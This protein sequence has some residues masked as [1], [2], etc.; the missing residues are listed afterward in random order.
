MSIWYRNYYGDSYYERMVQNRK[1]YYR[2]EIN[3]ISDDAFEKLVHVFGE[4]FKPILHK[5]ISVENLSELFKNHW[6][7]ENGRRS[8]FSGKIH[9][10]TELDFKE[11]LLDLEKIFKTNLKE[12]YN[13]TENMDYEFS[14]SGYINNINPQVN[15]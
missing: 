5:I 13:L 8:G 12:K 3:L 7:Q 2:Y 15:L 9:V 6:I 14:E 1:G 4:N 11:V 10:D